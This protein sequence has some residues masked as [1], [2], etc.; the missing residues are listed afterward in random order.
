MNAAPLRP[1]RLLLALSA[2]CA[3]LL[4]PSL[5]AGG[6]HHAGPRGA[7]ADLVDAQGLPGG[8]G[9]HSSTDPDTC[10]LCRA[11]SQVRTLLV[12]SDRLAAADVDAAPRGLH[13][14][15]AERLPDACVVA[16]AGP[17]APP[18]PARQR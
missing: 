3:S 13:P 17:R 2:L 15:L 14:P 4:L 12:A 1:L 18:A 5:H 10:S 7:A 9:S 6:A 8:H 11:A 16:V